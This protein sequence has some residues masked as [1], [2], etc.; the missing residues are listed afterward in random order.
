MPDA[1]RI[2]GADSIIYATLSDEG[3]H[4]YSLPGWPDRGFLFSSAPP[5]NINRYYGAYH[6]DYA[7]NS[8]FPIWI[9]RVY[10][11]YISP[12]D[13]SRCPMYPSCSQFALQAIKQK[14]TSGVIMT[15]DRLL[16]CG[17]DLGCYPLTFR[18]GRTLSYDPVN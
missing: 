7:H 3:P 16:R 4:E 2:E 8:S 17:R 14:G 18:D 1:S 15:F 13:R 6:D 11:K 5:C 12:V 10:Q 9:I